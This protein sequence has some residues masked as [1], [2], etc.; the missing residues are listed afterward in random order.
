MTRGNAQFTPPSRCRSHQYG[1]PIHPVHDH[2]HHW[3]GFALFR[4]FRRCL[5]CDCTTSTMLVKTFSQRHW[6]MIHTLH[7]DTTCDGS[8]QRQW[9]WDYASPPGPC[10]ISC[11]RPGHPS[12]T[13]L[14]SHIDRNSTRQC[15]NQSEYTVAITSGDQNQTYDGKDHRQGAKRNGIEQFLEDD[16]RWHCRATQPAVFPR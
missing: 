11:G 3:S 9:Y 5:H 4:C 15:K 12:P 1:P 6:Q 8:H 10:G 13:S 7:I 2:E 14:L 16:E